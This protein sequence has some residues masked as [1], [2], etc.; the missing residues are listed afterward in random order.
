M[1]GSEWKGGK[2]ERTNN[3]EKKLIFSYLLTFLPNYILTFQ[4]QQNL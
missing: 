1:E 2:D 3:T 4:Q